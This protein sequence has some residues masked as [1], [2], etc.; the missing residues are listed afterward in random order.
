VDTT[1]T[2]VH[3]AAA[4]ADNIYY[5]RVKAKDDAGNWGTSVLFTYKLDTT[6]PTGSILINSGATYTSS[7]DVTLTLSA[8]DA[9]SGV[10]EMC[11]S[12]DGM[13]WSSWEPYATSKAWTMTAGDG[14]KTVYVKF[15]DNVNIESSVYSDTITLDTSAPSG[16]ILI[17]SGVE[18]TTSTSVTL[19]LSASDEGSG[20]SQMVLSNDGVFD[21]EPWETY[22]T[23]KAW[24]L[25]AGDG[26]KT[27]YVKYKDVAGGVSAVYTDSIVLD[28]AA[29]SAYMI[30]IN[31][32][33]PYTTSVDVI[34]NLAA[35]DDGSGV[36]MMQFSNDGTSYSSW[37]PYQDT[38]PWTLTSGDGVKTVYVK[39]RDRAGGV[40]GAITDTI[41]LS[42]GPIEVTPTD[43]GTYKSSAPL[44]WEW[45]DPISSGIDGYYICIGTFPGGSDIKLDIWVANGADPQSYS[46]PTG[47]TPSVY[48]QNVAYYAK[49]KIKFTDG[50]ISDYGP[51]SDGIVYTGSSG[52]KSGGGEYS[53]TSDGRGVVVDLSEEVEQI[54]DSG[55]Q[56]ADVVEIY[57]QVDSTEGEWLN[58]T[59]VFL[60]APNDHSNDGLHIV[61]FYVVDSEGEQSP[62]MSVVV[63]IDTIAPEIK[64]IHPKGSGYETT[65]EILELKGTTEV[66]A[67]VL[68]NGENITLDDNGNFEI[69]VELVIGINEI[70]IVT[71]DAFGNRNEVVLKVVRKEEAASRKSQDARFE[72]RVSKWITANWG[73]LVAGILMTVVVVALYLKFRSGKL[74]IARSRGPRRWWEE[75]DLDKGKRG[76]VRK[77]VVRM[78]VKKKRGSDRQ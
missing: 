7:T 38:F 35:F 5:F 11:F 48:Y 36:F 29:P 24:T 27:V 6:G 12:N 69:E 31:N 70:T 63:L 62:I 15:R 19:T 51:S 16:S 55:Y 58:G 67:V 44:I 4:Q 50:T 61:Y 32:G 57:Y 66:D 49:V 45:N 77:R 25:T 54:S 1:S 46:L 9:G 73:Y 56:M 14:T 34:L 75:L 37:A 68:I 40:S 33:D 47:E 53:D 2:S 21:T 10:A 28:T 18:Y 39:F 59:E 20:V 74:V 41:I 26:T 60:S 72:E 43:E 52:V 78:K 71:E 30:L 76:K 3:Y 13:S 8:T 22:A 65:D 42:S 17:D 64:L 23:S